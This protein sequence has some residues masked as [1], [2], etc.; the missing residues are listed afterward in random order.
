M[1]PYDQ[2][3]D[4]LGVLTTTRSVVEAARRVR[5]DPARAEAVADEI[6]ATHAE[7]PAWNDDLHFRDGTW[8]TAGWVMVLDALNFCFWST[9]PD[10]R[11]RWRV[12]YRGELYDGYWALAAALRR[13]VD[14]GRPIWDPSY[15]LRL[16]PRDI[17]HILRPHDLAFP[18]IPLF[19]ARV[20]NLHELGRGLMAAYPDDNPVE[21]FIRDAGLSAARL[22]ERVVATFPSFNDVATYEGREVRFYKRAQILAADLH[23]AFGGEGLGTFDDLEVLT[24]FADYKVPQVLRR[25]GVIVY[26]EALTAKIDNR[27]L[28][29]T[30][31][32]EEV[33][34]RAATVW[35]CELVRQSL[36]AR[37]KPLRA[38]EV[39][40]ALWLAGQ[41]L[42]PDARPYHRTYTVFY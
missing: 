25:L 33:E 26:D 17:A 8:H 28:I 18:E 16:S 7:P 21:A 19:P 35:G 11:Q 40:W 14:E 12:Q 42:P 5:I 29:P 3:P 24:A 38:F 22:V 30:G 34:I 23:G 10:P 13:A 27:V 37:G 6:A 39:D 9:D 4:P 1:E 31:S 20:L 36:A 15:L 2:P 32:P 41:A